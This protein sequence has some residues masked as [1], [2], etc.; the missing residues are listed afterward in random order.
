MRRH[1]R[2]VGVGAHA[3]LDD[4]HEVALVFEVLDAQPVLAAE[5]DGREHDS[6]SLAT[7][8]AQ[9]PTQSVLVHR[10]QDGCLLRETPG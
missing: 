1:V 6:W 4:E 3:G 8:A 9:F 7:E 10:L 2:R 5:C